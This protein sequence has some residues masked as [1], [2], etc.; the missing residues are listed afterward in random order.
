M[1]I[2]LEDWNFVHMEDG[3]FLG[4]GSFGPG[5]RA[6]CDAFQ[7]IGGQWCELHQPDPARRDIRGGAFR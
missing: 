6:Q 2:I 3:R 5:D 1:S 4:D 7:E